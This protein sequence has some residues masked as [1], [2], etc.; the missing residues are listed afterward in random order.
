M[1]NSPKKRIASSEWRIEAVLA[2]AILVL[3]FRLSLFAS[4]HPFLLPLFATRQSLFASSFPTPTRGGRSAGGAR[5][6]ARHPS[7]RVMTDAQTPL[8]MRKSGEP[9]LRS[10]RTPGG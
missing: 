9:G 3:T 7:R 10:L 8:D 1:S 2:L 4:H 5:M 6:H